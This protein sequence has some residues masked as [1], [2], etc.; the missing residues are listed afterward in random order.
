MAANHA[1]EILTHAVAEVFLVPT[2]VYQ[3]LAEHLIH[4]LADIS[5]GSM[6]LAVHTLVQV[7]DIAWITAKV[8]QDAKLSAV[9]HRSQAAAA[10]AHTPTVAVAAGAV[11][12]LVA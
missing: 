3:Q 12:A 9:L 6:F 10:V 11:T 8:Y 2:L 5:R 1:W 7:H 4:L